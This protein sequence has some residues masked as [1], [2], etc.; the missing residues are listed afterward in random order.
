MKW[1]I[2]AAAAVVVVAVAVVALRPSVQS[3]EEQI[4]AV[5]RAG[6]AALEAADTKGA[7]ATLDED[8]SDSGGRKK[9]AMKGIAFLA[10]RRGPVLIAISDIK[11]DVEAGASTATAVV[12][13]VALQ[14]SA[15]VAE[16]KDLLPKRGRAF[17]ATL[18]FK[19]RGDDWLV[20]S[21]EGISAAF[22]GG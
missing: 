4:K 1:A 8:Y 14:G 13:G 2:A 19:K 12:T 15:T 20:T 7:L 16:A 9:G 21:I 18:S 6:Q 17:E 10:L 22:I 11:V 3:P 5:I